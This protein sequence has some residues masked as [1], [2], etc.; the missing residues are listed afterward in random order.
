MTNIA[1]W[2]TKP[3]NVI[4]HETVTFQHPDISPV[5][6]VA[7]QYEAALLGCQ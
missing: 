5:R 6:L 2:T 4:R 1:Y 7:N 3:N